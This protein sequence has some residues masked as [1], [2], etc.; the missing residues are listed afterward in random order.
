MTQHANRQ[1]KC[2]L[3]HPEQAPVDPQPAHEAVLPSWCLDVVL[4]HQRS[5]RCYIGVQVYVGHLERFT[6][7]GQLCTEASYTAQNEVKMKGIGLGSD[8]FHGECSAV[9][10]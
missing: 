5:Q 1:G 4:H 8:R 3:S 2:E 6:S 9:H 7:A 10:H